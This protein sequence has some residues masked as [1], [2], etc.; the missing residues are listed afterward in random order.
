MKFLRLLSRP[1]PGWFTILLFAGGV[2]T[3]ATV[4]PTWSSGTATMGPGGYWD[5][6]S[7]D[8]SITSPG[9][10]DPSIWNGS[11]GN[12]NLI[13]P[14]GGN[15]NL[16]NCTTA[17]CNTSA[18]QI[19]EQVTASQVAA[20]VPELSIYGSATAN[21][22][23]GPIPPCFTAANAPCALGY[24][25]HHGNLTIAIASAC[26][27]NAP[28]AISTAPNNGVV[29]FTN[30]AGFTSNTY[31]CSAINNDPTGE[32]TFAEYINGLSFQINVYNASATTLA[33]SATIATNWE[34]QGV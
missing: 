20:L 4:L 21:T 15:I 26:P 23:P 28:C 33:K 14:N 13:V 22:S 10:S 25:I 7:V 32:L 30:G 18:Q 31:S 9:P 24:H 27:P 5:L 16:R 12:E 3:A 34:C 1:L 2:A 19:T 17:T 8:A 6:G 29:T 11:G